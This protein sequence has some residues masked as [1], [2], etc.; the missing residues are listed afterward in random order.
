MI[1][2]NYNIFYS[3]IGILILAISCDS[4]QNKD[5]S[6]PRYSTSEEEWIN[7]P[8]S[9]RYVKYFDADWKITHYKS[10][11]SFYRIAYYRNGVI[12]V[13]SLATDYYITGEKQGEA[14]IFTE[15]P[16]KCNGKM[17]IFYK[18]G[19]L[20]TE[21]HYEYGIPIG[22]HKDYYETGRI[23]SESY[24][25]NGSPIGTWKAY[26]E[27]G[28]VKYEVSFS[29]G[30]KHG[31]CYFYNENGQ[32]KYAGMYKNGKESGVWCF[33]DERGIC[34]TLDYDYHSINN[35]QQ[36]T[37]RK[38]KSLSPQDAYDEGY[39]SGY[40]KGYEDGSDGR[41]FEY[42]YDDSSNYYDNY[43]EQYQVGYRDGYEEGY[44]SG[45]SIY[46]DDNDEDE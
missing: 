38:K 44:S 37:N 6:Y 11:A 29:D 35:Y 39:N 23:M 43:E 18:N 24:Y 8:N 17:L 4:H 2:K 41:Y 30:K 9:G 40:E 14:Y 12:V 22:E 10:K 15:S 27:N 1:S 45:K 42:G 32:V 25:K 21:A 33:Y 34:T 31:L 46:N 5:Y 28:N 19:K 3:V 26:Y 16:D 13:D 7:Y 20:K 36:Q